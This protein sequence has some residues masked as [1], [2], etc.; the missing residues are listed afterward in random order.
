MK[1]SDD[2]T[3]WH[4]SLLMIAAQKFMLSSQP[5]TCLIYT[6]IVTHAMECSSDIYEY[7]LEISSSSISMQHQMAAIT[8]A[9]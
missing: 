7:E 5:T 1:D 2:Y 9:N 3:R 8:H 4:V 6:A